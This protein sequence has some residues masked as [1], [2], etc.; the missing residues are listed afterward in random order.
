[1]K[2]TAQTKWSKIANLEPFFSEDTRK[3]MTEAAEAQFGDYYALTLDALFELLNGDF[4]AMLGNT[5][6]PTALQVAWAKGFAEFAK[7]L[8]DT[9]DG[10][11]I[12]PDAVEVRAQAGTLKMSFQ[13]GVLVFCRD[14]FG[15]PSFA[16]C[17]TLTV[18]DFLLAKKAAYNIAV[19]QRN[20]RTIQEQKFKRR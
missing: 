8:T 14:Y 6:D 5:D 18:G 1:M 2:I 10:M 19:A 9:L 3:A 13:E 20:M 17:G 11:T 12:K 4:S 16:A 15:L 7:T